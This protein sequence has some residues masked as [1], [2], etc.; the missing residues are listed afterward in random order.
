MAKADIEIFKSAWVV[1]L[2]LA[3]AAGFDVVEIHNAH[4]YLLHSFVSPAT[5]NGADE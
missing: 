3:L 2:K 5:N 1:S 4:G